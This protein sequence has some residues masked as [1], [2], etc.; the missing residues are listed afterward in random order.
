MKR[1]TDVLYHLWCTCR[2]SFWPNGVLAEARTP[3]DEATKMRTRVLCKAKMFGSVP[4][5]ETDF[6][7]SCC[8]CC[9]GGGDGGG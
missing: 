2:D 6:S 1:Q 3:R 7:L 8:C 4:G 9:G 5:E